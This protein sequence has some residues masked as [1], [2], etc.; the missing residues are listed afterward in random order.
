M[1]SFEAICVL[2]GVAW[3]ALDGESCHIHRI[4]HRLTQSEQSVQKIAT[5][6]FFRG[7]PPSICVVTEASIRA[8]P[9]QKWR[10]FANVRTVARYLNAVTERTCMRTLCFG[11]V[12]SHFWFD[13]LQFCVGILRSLF[14]SL[15]MYCNRF[16]VQLKQAF[17]NIYL[18][19]MT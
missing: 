15:K 2:S 6:I 7:N 10:C 16:M 3:V 19:T 17:V 1:L 11:I 12:R 4:L 18:L 14:E 5:F 9:W 8:Q 13:M